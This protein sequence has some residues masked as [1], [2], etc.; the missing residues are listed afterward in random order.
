MD[1]RQIE[2]ESTC[3]SEVGQSFIPG[4][5]SVRIQ[6]SNRPLSQGGHFVSGVLESFV[7]VRLAL[8]KQS[9]LNLPRQNVRHVTKGY[10]L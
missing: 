8:H 2:G 9:F 7:Y 4:T 6:H 1:I 5:T 10:R 3:L